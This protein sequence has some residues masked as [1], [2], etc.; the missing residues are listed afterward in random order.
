MARFDPECIDVEDYLS[1]LE[2][3]NVAK[4]TEREYRFSCPYPVHSLGDETPSC[5]MNSETTAFFCHSCHAKGNAVTMVTDVL[6]CSPIEATRMLKSRYS[7]GGIEPG[8]RNM[9]EEVLKIIHK[10][11]PIKREN[12]IL[13]EVVL[14]QYKVDWGFAWIDYIHDHEETTD[15]Q[16]Y[17]FDRGFR[18]QELTGWQFGWS[19]VSDRIT[20][21]IRDEDGHIVGIKARAIDNRKPKYLNLREGDIEPYLKNEI[22]FALDRVIANYLPGYRHIIVVEGELNAVAMHAYNHRTTV[23]LNGSYF[24]SR[25]IHLLKLYAD[26]VTL[27]FDSDSA[28]NDATVA[29]ADELRPFVPVYICPYHHG[30]PAEMHKAS[31]DAC[32]AD[33]ISI[34]KRRLAI[35]RT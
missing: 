14:N 4:V 16:K 24:G 18:P 13:P 23:A 10:K 5:Y 34:T 28:G 21:P 11:P 22:V 17:I 25:Q 29:V 35:V 26:S 9:V 20:L 33:R 12:V 6:G 15:Y 30:D 31:V 2:I 19:M 32:I 8:S 7:K 1:C 27:F 3:R